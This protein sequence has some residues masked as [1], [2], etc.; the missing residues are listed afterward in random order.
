MTGHASATTASTGGVERFRA[1]AQ[2]ALFGGI[3]EHIERLSWSRQQIAEVQRDRLRAL[4]A[5][6]AERSPFHAR[7]LAGIDPAGVELED[8]PRVPVMTKAEMMAA[9][10]EI[11]TDPRARRAAAEAAIA[12][13]TSTPVPIDDELVV[14]ASGGSSG[15]RGLFALS[16]TSFAEYA[17]TLMR[18]TMARLRALGGLP[19]GG[20]KLAIVGADSA[21]HAT[22]VA[23]AVLD[24]GPIRFR[25][26]PATLP[27]DEI[28]HRLNDLQPLG[29]Y[30]YRACWPA[31]PPSRPRAAC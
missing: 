8:L 22:G 19:P 15:Q 25:P 11:V 29:L 18:P 2:D 12:A 4:L 9:F 24:G 21:I 28:V 20:I 27:L 31:S 3:D 30:G 13:T 10:D 1:R 26:V 5:V 23:P 7:R 14:L 17:C 16:V 6:A